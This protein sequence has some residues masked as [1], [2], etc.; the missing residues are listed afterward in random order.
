MC[1]HIECICVCVCVDLCILVFVH[2][3]VYLD[4]SACLFDCALL[5]SGLHNELTGCGLCINQNYKHGCRTRATFPPLW[6]LAC[7]PVSHH[8]NIRTELLHSD[9]SYSLVGYKHIVRC[10]SHFI[11][12]MFL[13]CNNANWGQV[14][15]Q[16]TNM[17]SKVTSHKLTSGTIRKILR[18]WCIIHI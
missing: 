16:N 2:V 11:L 8:L 10:N 17:K 4:L 3:L 5:H 7:F 9:W 6:I 12:R 1:L 13:A 14:A 15:G 18:I